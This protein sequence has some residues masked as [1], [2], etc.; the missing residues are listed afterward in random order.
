MTAWTIHH[1]NGTT[2]AIQLDPPSPTRTRG[3]TVS[4]SFDFDTVHAYDD[5]AQYLEY[6]GSVATGTLKDGT[7]WYR[8]LHAESNQSLLLGFEPNPDI[9][10]VDGLWG[11]LLSGEEQSRIPPADLRLTVEVFYLAPFPDHAD[12]TAVRTVYER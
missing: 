7:P 8:E 4:M 5:I 9:P 12:L 1:D 2:T 6:A 3:G 11:V 10:T